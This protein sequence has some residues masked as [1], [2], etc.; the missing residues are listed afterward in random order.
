[1]LELVRAE[2]TRRLLSKMTENADPGEYAIP[3][4][5]LIWVNVVS[6]TENVSVIISCGKTIDQNVN[7][8]RNPMNIKD[9]NQRIFRWPFRRVDS[10]VKSDSLFSSRMNA[11][12]TR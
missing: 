2:G 11:L 7:A 8:N 9:R 6:W 5:A 12:W 1:V 3:V 4:S 10:S